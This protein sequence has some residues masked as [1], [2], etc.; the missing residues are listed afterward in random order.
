M[1]PAAAAPAGRRTGPSRFLRLQRTRI[2]AI[3]ALEP[4]AHV[5]AGRGRCRGRRDDRRRTGLSTVTTSDADAP[6][7]AQSRTAPPSSRCAMP[8]VT[9]FSTS[10]CSS[11]GG[12]SQR[13]GVRRRRS[14]PQAIAEPH[15][16]DGEEA[17]RQRQLARRAESG[18]RRRAP[19]CRAG[20][21]RA[22]GTSAAPPRGSAV[23]SALIDCRLLKR[24]CGSICARSARSSASRASTCSSSPRRSASRDDR[25]RRGEIAHR[26]REQVEQERRS[27]RA[28]APPLGSAAAHRATRRTTRS[29]PIQPR[30]ISSQT[31]LE[32][33]RRE[34]PR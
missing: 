6:L 8:C 23:V 31:A 14:R 25:E 2:A 3:G 33:E 18:S 4:L 24:K 12:T 26:H 28:S 27:R 10:G 29:A 32:Q 16:L 13:L 7:G 1:P 19:A 34:R 15:L 22:A 11:S 9:A 17:A 20:S 21:R 5:R 30:A